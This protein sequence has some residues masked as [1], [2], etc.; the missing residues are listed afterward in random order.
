MVFIMLL[1]SLCKDALHKQDYKIEDEVDAISSKRG[2]RR[3]GKR[4]GDEDHHGGH[5]VNPQQHWMLGFKDRNL[6]EEY[7]EFLA[8]GSRKRLL[9]GYSYCL[10]LVFFTRILINVFYVFYTLDI[11]SDSY[12]RIIASNLGCP[13]A[14]FVLFALGLVATLV[15][16]RGERIERK[17]VSLA[18]AEGV[19]VVY[20]VIAAVNLTLTW[21]DW[22]ILLGGGGWLYEVATESLPEYL[23]LFFINLPF[24]EN[25]VIVFFAMLAVFVIAPLTKNMWND[26]SYDWVKD[27]FVNNMEALGKEYETACSK[28][29][30]ECFLVYKVSSMYP[31]VAIICFAAA[32]IVFVSFFTDQSNRQAFMNQKLV[33]VLTEQKEEALENLV[34]SI[35][36]KNIAAQLIAETQDDNLPSE[37]THSAFN[38]ITSI[39][40][41]GTPKIGQLEMNKLG[42]TVARMHHSVTILF[43]DIVGF[44]EMSK[45][46]TPYEVMQFLHGLFSSFDNLLDIDPRLWKVET[47]GDAFMVASGL[48]ENDDSGEM[49]KGE[50]GEEG[51]ME[52]E[53]KEEEEREERGPADSTSTYKDGRSSIETIILLKETVKASQK[54]FSSNL[55][56]SGLQSSRSYRHSSAQAAVI[57]GKAALREAAQY[58]MPNMVVCQIRV[59]VHTGDVCSGV[60]GS[61]MPRYCLF[62]DTVN[63]ASRMES[64]SLPGRMQISEETHALVR[65]SS[66]FSWEER[67]HVDVKGKGDMKTYLLRENQEKGM[68][69][70]TLFRY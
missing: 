56:M 18:I 54:H 5:F 61:R 65:E 55:V 42:R 58:V 46:C 23:A 27:V 33:R 45:S 6:E 1:T 7:L 14:N 69:D 29:N 16:Y 67:G 9:L 32:A 49:K 53:E 15:V 47:I 64:T 30:K 70:N 57:F 13:L 48:G 11:K 60:V 22:S 10:L 36:P 34:L 37:S 41:E 44:T 17:R 8:R 68:L 50:E 63:T 59:G 28:S 31:S 12:L 40:R 35:F 52:R 26:F 21:Y 62:G 3:G 66:N 25:M 2:R 51:A 19:F 39:T 38:S 24:A 20:A 4:A 43:S